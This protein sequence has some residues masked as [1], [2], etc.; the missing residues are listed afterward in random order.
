MTYLPF[1]YKQPS[2]DDP[3]GL[4]AAPLIACNLDI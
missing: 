1:Q 3:F 2:V 4:L